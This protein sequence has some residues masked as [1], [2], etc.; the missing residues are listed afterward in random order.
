V[1]A[2]IAVSGF[3]TWSYNVGIAVY[4]YEMTH[5]AFWVAVVTV[6]RYLP[7]I[8]LS[9][10][11]SGLVDRV[12]RRG[13]V[14]VSDL[15]C[16]G[17]MTVLSLL[18]AAGSPVWVLTVVAAVSS[19]AARIQAAGVLAL[20]A[21][22]V[23]ESQLARASVLAAASEAVATAAG[24]AAA[25]LLLLRFD[26]ATLFALNAASFVVSA[27]LV[28]F[29]PSLPVRR[30]A[31]P[32]PRRS[33]ETS[34]ATARAQVW[35]LQA[36]RTV[37]AYVYGM[38]VVLL[39]VVA[40]RQL[41][42]GTSGYGWL[43]AAA[44]LGGILVLAPARRWVTGR[45]M[46]AL[47]SS[48]AMGCYCLPL[49]LFAAAPPPAAGLAIQVVRGA[50]AVLVTSSVMSALQW[51][52]PSAEAGRVFG[53]TQSLVLVGTCAGSL[54]TP[55][56]LSTLGFRTT[57]VVG[58]LVPFAAQLLL[59][60][61]LRRFHRRDP[62]LAAAL[63]P[64]LAV[65]R[66]LDLLRDASR[67]TLYAVAD[68]VTELHP[69]PGT[70]LIAE[71]DESDALYVIVSGEVEVTGGPERQVYRHQTGPDY[72]GEIGLIHGIRR[73]ASVTTVSECEV[74]RVPGEVFLSAT[75]EAGASGALMDTMRIRFDTTSGRAPITPG[76]ATA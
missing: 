15:V 34:P 53:T 36:S 8:V 65:L 19:T 71:G 61:L 14:I 73:T 22:V 48:T 35:P 20:A 50:G 58:A 46:S 12:P 3:G 21:D 24:S 38:D 75:S 45:G 64:R 49:L 29:V 5:S 70:P 68:S 39:T 16:A 33:R 52:V 32:N 47:V 11:M 42:S 62:Q 1:I 51:A 72:V 44:G 56:L 43:L 2:S 17:V 69:G 30:H 57:L 4:A 59:Q 13:L 54:S 10:S 28:A 26:P 40:A 6:G 9:W 27:A 18:G 76:I 25:S 37:A 55:V 23:V 31:R 7:A 74:W 60:P 41:G 66:R 67:A 63:D